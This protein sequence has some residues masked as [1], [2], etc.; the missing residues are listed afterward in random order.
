MTARSFGRRGSVPTGG[1]ALRAGTRTSGS[2]SDRP[3]LPRDAA[4]GLFAWQGASGPMFAIHLVNLALTAITL[5]IYRFWA[6]TRMR[7]YLWSNMALFGEMLEYT[8][9]GGELFRGMLLAVL[10]VL[11]PAIVGLGL[12]E[13][14]V[15]T[16]APFFAPAVNLIQFCALGFLLAVGIFRARRYKLSRTLWRGIR[17]GQDGSSLTYGRIGLVAYPLAVITLGLS[18]PLTSFAMAKYRASHTWFG[19]RKFDFEGRT[20]PLYRVFLPVW[21]IY[22]AGVAGVAI[23]VPSLARADEDA[24]D[25]MAFGPM[26]AVVLVLVLLGVSVGRIPWQW[27]RAAEYRYFAECLRFGETRFVAD[28]SGAALAWLYLGNLVILA[29]TLGLGA[30]LVY[31]RTARFAAARLSASG[32]IDPDQVLQGIGEISSHGEGLADAL[33]AGEF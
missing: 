14:G 8:G 22:A 24:F 19:D 29:L 21:G 5:G 18:W 3:P 10:L 27:Y 23:L 6:K 2:D 9:T 16:F 13:A 26:Q 30:P 4:R 33:D 11:V 1:I 32:D 31:G 7:R 25:P 12:L 20:G 28:I 15:R 17:F